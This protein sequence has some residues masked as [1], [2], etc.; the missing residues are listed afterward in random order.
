[1]NISNCLCIHN[2]CP[3]NCNEKYWSCINNKCIHSDF[4]FDFNNF[5]LIIFILII[6]FLSSIAGVGGGGLLLPLYYIIGKFRTYYTIPLC[7]ITISGNSLCRLL[8]LY[9]KRH[10]LNSYRY[11]I[12]YLLLLIIIPF[13]S[14]FS[15]LGFIFNIIT[16]VF[17]INII[18]ISLLLL[19]GIKTLCKSYKY[20]KK[21]G[22]TIVE[23]I[24]FNVT[25]INSIEIDGINIDIKS[26]DYKRI[27]EG[28]KGELWYYPYCYL[29]VF[30]LYCFISYF[31]VFLKSGLNL[32]DYNFIIFSCLQ[33]FT[34]IIIGIFI[35]IYVNK[36]QKNRLVNNFFLLPKEIIWNKYNIIIFAIASALISIISTFL[37]IGGGMIFVPFMIM[38]SIPPEIASSTNA[39]S[40]FFSSVT[41]SIQYIGSDRI[42]PYYSIMFFLTSFIGS[43]F[44]LK[45]F[46]KIIGKSN[47]NSYIV[48]LLGV[49]I[50]LSAIIMI[51]MMI[52]NNNSEI[53]YN[54]ICI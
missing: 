36:I 46:K 20:F 34:F 4:I 30:I 1:M 28:K 50:L 49:I 7:V 10:Y 15:I 14:A 31:F 11:L 19:I 38:N 35:S 5:L 16:P 44:G 54:N 32:C 53:K 18:M 12:N 42:L 51:V 9:N 22:N 41:S 37:G 3:L 26:E 21:K 39:I 40:T 52:N 47:K 13:D 2:D 25:A 17:V 29:L 43:Y 45:S 24:S 33:I 23:G 27:I 6:S 8:I 48:I